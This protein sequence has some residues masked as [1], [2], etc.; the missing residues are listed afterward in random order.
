MHVLWIVLTVIFALIGIFGLIGLINPDL[1]N[2]ELKEGQEPFNRKAAV[3]LLVT[4][5]LLC[6]P[7]FALA[8]HHPD[9]SK[10]TSSQVKPQ[11]PASLNQIITQN[12]NNDLGS[13]NSSQKKR[14]VS[15]QVDM[16][17]A[18]GKSVTITLNGDDNLTNNLT[19]KGLQMNSNPVFKSAFKNKEVNCVIVAWQLPLSDPYG[20][21]SDEVVMR[22]KLTRDTFNKIDWNNFDFQ[23]YPTIADDYFEHP[24]LNK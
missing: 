18:G 17:S 13:R 11:K 14:V 4:G 19:K 15:V 22:I 1:F 20:K 8:A 10:A 24:A 12:V 23:N 3:A 5:A 2:K 21:T 7:C 6:T 16:Y 9:T